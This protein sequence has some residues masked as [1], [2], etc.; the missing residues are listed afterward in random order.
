MLLTFIS[1]KHHLVPLDRIVSICGP[2]ELT[3]DNVV[4]GKALACTSLSFLQN[5][6]DFCRE[7]Y[8]MGFRKT[9]V[10]K[11]FSSPKNI[12]EDKIFVMKIHLFIKN[13]ERDRARERERRIC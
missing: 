10:E 3:Q 11:L 6:L 7:G 5:T 4:T 12:Q 13:S 8:A 9:T 2:L 1:S